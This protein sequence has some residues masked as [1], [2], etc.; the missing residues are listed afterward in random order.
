MFLVRCSFQGPRCIPE[1]LLEDNCLGIVTWQF[2]DSYWVLG[3]R[4]RK[5]GGQTG[6]SLYSL[7]GDPGPQG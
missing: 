4:Q 1:G 2:E 6:D 5:F 3:D 7:L